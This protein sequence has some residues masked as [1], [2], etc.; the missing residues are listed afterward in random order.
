M[1]EI[2]TSWIEEFETYNDFYKENITNVDINFLFLDKEGNIEKIQTENT[3]LEKENFLSK[4][5]LIYILKKTI[6]T[7]KRKYSLLSIFKFNISLNEEEVKDVYNEKKYD[8]NEYITNIPGIDDIMWEKSIN[9]FKD[10]NELNII[11]MEK[12]KNKHNTR[13]VYIEKSTNKGTRRK[14]N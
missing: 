6:L 14:Y 13:R 11:L 1:E 4:E 8:F 2:D 5:Q 9:I 12:K 3:I 10:M 7:N